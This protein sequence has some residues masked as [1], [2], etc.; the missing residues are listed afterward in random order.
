VISINLARRLQTTGVT[1]SPVAG[2]RFAIPDREMDDDVF[3]ISDMVVEVHDL[4]LGRLLGFNGTTEWALDSIP[5]GEALWLPREEQLR[6]MLGEAFVGLGATPGGFIVTVV[7]DGA[8][9][10]HI[11]IDAECAYARAVLAVRG[12]QEEREPG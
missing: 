3:V 6:S 7:R 8:E 1:W 5:Q 12:R 11:D 4:P 9:E 2:D 10:R